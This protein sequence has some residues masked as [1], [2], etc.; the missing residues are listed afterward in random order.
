[1]L[2]DY[3]RC[4][5]PLPGEAVEGFITRGNGIRVHKKRCQNL[6]ALDPERRIA[7]EWAE[8]HSDSKHTGEIEITCQDRPGMLANIT[9]VCETSKVN[10][11]QIQSKELSDDR[12]VCTLRLAVRDIEELSRLIK[13]IGKIKG[14][15]EVHR[16]VG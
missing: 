16:L 4:C 1:M 11:Q 13:N 9:R 7:V 12:A 2:V 6:D 15:D 3:A 8:S 5:G 14:V 10:I